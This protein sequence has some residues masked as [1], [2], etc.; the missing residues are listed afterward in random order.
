[1]QLFSRSFWKP[2]ATAAWL[3]CAS[4][5]GV[6]AHAQDQQFTQFNAAPTSFNPAYAGVSGKARLAS[7]YRSQWTAL[8]QA[9]TGFHLAYDRPTLDKRMG[10]GFLLSNEQAGA[11]SLNRIQFM[12][13][14]AHNL[15]LGRRLNLRTGMQL[16]FGARS[17]DVP[18][19]V[20]S[21]VLLRDN[22]TVSVEQGLGAGTQYMDM[23]A[24][25]MLLSR[26]VWFGASANHLTTPN[27]SLNPALPER[28]AVLYTGHGGARIQL[29]RGPHGRFRRD[30]VVSW[31]YIQQGD[32]NQLDVGAYY[33]LSLF[34][35]G[36]WY[37][38]LPVQQSADGSLDVDALSFVFGF[39]NRD[40][41][42]G[43]SYD[44]TLNRLGVLGTAGSH[45]F[46]VK[47]FWDVA[48][49][50]DPQP[51]YHPCVEY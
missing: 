39:G 48:R 3:A 40:F 50:R 42:M 22:A 44:I 10:F 31:K 7:L 29:A 33:D 26:R 12:G 9:F 21:V 30:V 38:G 19:L 34:T 23:G 1:M 51:P 27:V 15:R 2:A 47:Y 18:T 8:P 43:Y 45:E 36:L 16:C 24:G 41:K 20:F 6:T 25:F 35:L 37:R 49:R 17:F 32:R 46:S 28:L 4:L 5:A 14:A 11:G 13:Q